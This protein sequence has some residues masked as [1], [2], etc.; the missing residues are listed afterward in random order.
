MP[1]KAVITIL[2]TIMYDDNN[3][4]KYYYDEH[5]GDL[6]P[7]LNKDRYANML[8][9]LLEN[10]DGYDIVS[11]Y[12]EVSLQK[13]QEVI[14]HYEIDY[15]IAKNG[16]FI[17]SDSDKDKAGYKYFL[18]ALNEAIDEYD[19]VIMDMTHGFRHLP[20]LS[21]IDL[22]MQNIKDP[23]KIEHILFAK[24]I[25]PR[26]EYEII[27][28]LEYLELANLS[29]ALSSFAKN[30]TI[31]GNFGF[32][33]SDYQKL[34][35]ELSSFS[36]NILANSLKPLIEG[37]LIGNI[38]DSL[39]KLVEDTDIR[40]FNG[41]IEDIKR[42]LDEILQLRKEDEWMRTYRLSIVMAER[43][44]LLN[45]I[46]LLYEATGLYC[47]YRIESYS[48]KL[49]E[50]ID[51]FRGFIAQGREPTYEFSNYTLSSQSRKIIKLGKAFRGDYLYNPETADWSKTDLNRAKRKRAPIPKQESK[52]IKQ[53]IVDMTDRLDISSFREYLGK[54]DALRNNMAHG[55]SSVV[56]SEINKEF[57]GALEQFRHFCI[58]TD[59]LNSKRT[60]SA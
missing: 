55:N 42:H 38:K 44:Y 2:G 30:Y 32:R 50:H 9:L 27:D 37:D 48:P 15:D 33:N 39:Q 41:Y 58:T 43:G 19:N 25:S 52:E 11:I 12:T 14:G 29:Y 60:N 47:L 13:Q 16:L 49:K 7:K 20:I 59:V 4:A 8:P 53:C 34:F 22:I 35:D 57:Q 5:L 23:N 10:F 17:A 28:L 26:K 6:M 54:L 24:E 1:K 56:V 21:M 51:R 31:S 36:D 3:N 40:Y 18:N 45:A 46:T